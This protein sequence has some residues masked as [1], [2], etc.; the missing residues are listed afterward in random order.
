MNLAV[1]GGAGFIGTHLTQYLVNQGHSV[2]VIDNLHSGKIENLNNVQ[3]EIE[4]H[5]IS[6]L[7]F[8]E[9][10][11]AIKNVDGVF[12]EAA[13]TEVQESFTRKAEYYD[14]NVKGTQNLL[15]IG[16]EFGFKIVFASSS[17]IYGNVTRIPVKENF[18]KK[19]INPY[20]LTKLEAEYLSEKYAKLGVQVVGLRYFNVYGKGQS[21]SYAGVI[22]KFLERIANRKP[23]IINGDGLQKRDFV[24]V[25]DVTKANLL[26]MKSKENCAFLNIGSGKSISILELANMII[27]FSG[28]E[29]KPLHTKPLEGDIMASE[30]DISLAKKIINWEPQTKLVDWLEE[31]VSGILK[32]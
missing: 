9:L 5:K 2:I 18:E 23:P 7:E 22:T 17:S 10:K 29:M 32:K 12:H 8:E 19:P 14:V 6:I 16:R 28:L 13:L 3:N 4:F 25:S 24:F 11:N 26:A 27:N 1:T 15:E 21:I 31:T 20:G 30:A